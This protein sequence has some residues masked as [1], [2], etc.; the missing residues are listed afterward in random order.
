VTVLSTDMCKA[1]D[2]LCHSVTAKKKLDVYDFGTGS[3]DL[4]RS[5]FD[6]RLNRMKINAQIS[7]WKTLERG[8]LPLGINF[9][10]K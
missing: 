10:I 1:F 2:S 9:S 8:L 6:E 3:L 5:F 4:I 7:E